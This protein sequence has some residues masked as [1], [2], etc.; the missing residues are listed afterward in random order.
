MSVCILMLQLT[1]KDPLPARSPGIPEE[2]WRLSPVARREVLEL[3]GKIYE[4]FACN[5]YSMNYN[6]EATIHNTNIYVY[7]YIVNAVWSSGAT[8]TFFQLRNTRPES[9]WTNEPSWPAPELIGAQN[10]K[11]SEMHPYISL[12]IPQNVQNA[13]GRWSKRWEW[14]DWGDQAW[15]DWDHWG[16]RLSVALLLAVTRRALQ[17]LAPPIEAPGSGVGTAG[18]RVPVSVEFAGKRTRHVRSVLQAY[19]HLHGLAW[20]CTPQSLPPSL[21]G[22]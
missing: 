6:I 22:V 18:R 9:N 13:L 14:G 8:R 15:S 3:I 17:C 7:V 5:A 21:C 11:K 1:A 19:N 2:P 20:R 10:P 16:A 4:H 12:H